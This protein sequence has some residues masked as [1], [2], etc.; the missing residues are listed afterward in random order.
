MNCPKDSIFYQQNKIGVLVCNAT[1]IPDDF[2]VSRN[3]DIQK[4]YNSCGDDL[5]GSLI[6]I[7]ESECGGKS[8]FEIKFSNITWQTSGTY[9]LS[10]TFGN[11]TTEQ[12][13]TIVVAGKMFL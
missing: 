2:N 10:L 13:F 3:I 9:R 1:N 12:N 4:I 11:S 6:K 7:A 5:K 8:C